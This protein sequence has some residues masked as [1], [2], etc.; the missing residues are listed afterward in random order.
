MAQ[1]NPRVQLQESVYGYHCGIA[2]GRLN[3]YH[4]EI[5]FFSLLWHGTSNNR[6]SRKIQV[7]ETRPSK[8]PLETPSY[9]L[10]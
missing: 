9:N 6:R 4:L 8:S 10:H 3:F 5:L 2:I 1:I 7:S